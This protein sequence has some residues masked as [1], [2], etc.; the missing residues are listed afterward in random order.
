MSLAEEG[1]FFLFPGV[2][3]Y[4]FFFFWITFHPNTLFTSSD[5]KFMGMYLQGF[6][7]KTDLPI[8]PLAVLPGNATYPFTIFVQ[9]AY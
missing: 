6:S 3:V 8:S 2:C 4:N 5:V 1:L 9:H 7:S